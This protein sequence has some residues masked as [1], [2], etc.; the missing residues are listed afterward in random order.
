MSRK[1]F[2]LHNF[3][4]DIRLYDNQYECMYIHFAL[5]SKFSFDRIIIIRLQFFNIL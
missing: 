1:W 4:V 5:Q 3:Y 2:D